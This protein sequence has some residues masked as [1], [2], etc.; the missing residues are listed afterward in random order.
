MCKRFKYDTSQKKIHE[1]PMS[2]EKMFTIIA[3]QENKNRNTT[4]LPKWLKLKTLTI[5]SVGKDMEQLEFSHMAGGDM[6]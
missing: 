2:Q 5:L 6:K 3:H 1:W 4:Y